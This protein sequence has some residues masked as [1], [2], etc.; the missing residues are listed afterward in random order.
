MVVRKGLIDMPSPRSGFYRRTI[1][2]CKD[3]CTR[4]VDCHPKCEKYKT[5]Q[6]SENN[7]KQKAYAVYLAEREMADY[8]VRMCEKNKKRWKR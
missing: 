8:Q 4:S 7:E 2:P 3:C 5:W 1:P 6:E